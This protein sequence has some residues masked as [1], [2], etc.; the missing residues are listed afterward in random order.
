MMYISAKIL[1]TD[2]RQYLSGNHPANI[3]GTIF[4][5]AALAALL[6]PLRWLLLH[7]KIGPVV[8]CIVK[9]FHDVFYV[10]VITM[11]MVTAIAIGS[12]TMLKPF[13][14]AKEHSVPPNVNETYVL[15]ESNMV[16]FAGMMRGMAW[17]LFNPGSPEY[18][19][20]RRCNTTQ[21]DETASDF[22]KS[23]DH[24]DQDI[25][26]GKIKYFPF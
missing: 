22:C 15:H 26:P 24:D 8:V 3:G 17:R 2:N 9:V 11:I 20:V 5:F 12:F 23:L 25:V 13:E 21:T 16:V 19:T 18:F 10:M 4:A 7:Q 6:R 1:K 14:L